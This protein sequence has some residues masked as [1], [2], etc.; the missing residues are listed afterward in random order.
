MYASRNVYDSQLRASSKFNEPIERVDNVL[1][2]DTQAQGLDEALLSWHRAF[3]R[4]RSK[5]TT[6]K[7]DE[8]IYFGANSSLTGGPSQEL[9]SADRMEQRSTVHIQQSIF[10]WALY[11]D[12]QKHPNPT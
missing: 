10:L 8:K 5:A 1:G 3:G 7:N 4:T 11:P 2:S 6:V 9:V 12:N